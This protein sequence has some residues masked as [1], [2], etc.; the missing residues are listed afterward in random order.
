MWNHMM[1]GEAPF[2]LYA[3]GKLQLALKPVISSWMWRDDG[4]LVFKFLGS[5]EVT[6]VMKAKKNSW[7]ASVSKYEICPRKDCSDDKVTVDGPAVASELAAD[8]R[9][10]KYAKIVVTLE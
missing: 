9:N 8:I 1:V 2:S 10:L 6:Y 7:E 3:N 5:I 4:T